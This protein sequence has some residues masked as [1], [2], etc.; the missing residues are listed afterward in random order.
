MQYASAKNKTK[1]SAIHTVKSTVAKLAKHGL[2][3]NGS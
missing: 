3:D 1:D 2:D